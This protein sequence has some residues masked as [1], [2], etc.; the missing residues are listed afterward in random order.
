M[1]DD[2]KQKKE[3]LLTKLLKENPQLSM[4]EANVSIREAFDT[5]MAPP[6]FS[7][8]KKEL[9]A[10]QALAAEAPA[11]K[12][13]A[14]TPK[15]KGKPKAEK[16]PAA[17]PKAK[18]VPKEVAEKKEVVEE[19]VDL[20][21]GSEAKKASDKE[22]KLKKKEAKTKSLLG[23]AEEKPKKTRPKKSAKVADDTPEDAKT[24]SS[25]EAS[26]ENT[27][28]EAK[29]VVK[30]E[31]PEIDPN[32]PKHV[33]KLAVSIPKASEVHLAGSFNRWR[34]S[35]FALIKN[36]DSQWTFEGELPEGTYEYKFVVD[37]KVWFLDMEASRVID[38]TGVSHRIEIPQTA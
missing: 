15:I 20:F 29:K 3:E 5:G 11:P 9:F 16:K 27:P 23:D 13:E 22:D 24:E 34:T 19:E 26:N 36:D 1:S 21:D 18:K 25:E 28:V 31:E 14:P 35:E 7:R 32:L 33:V 12:A 10:G 37:Q 6:A 8:I 38:K 17:K 2:I 30:E 4:K